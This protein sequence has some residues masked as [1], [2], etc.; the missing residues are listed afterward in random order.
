MAEPNK[1]FSETLEAIELLHPSPSRHSPEHSPPPTPP[2]SFTYI[3]EEITT[4]LNIIPE[5]P[6]DPFSYSPPKSFTISAPVK[7]ENFTELFTPRINTKQSISNEVRKSTRLSEKRVSYVNLD[8]DSKDCIQNQK[9]FKPSSSTFVPYD[10]KEAKKEKMLDEIIAKPVN[11]ATITSPYQT[12]FVPV[13]SSNRPLSESKTFDFVDMKKRHVHLDDVLQII[14]WKAFCEIDEFIYSG[15]VQKFYHSATILEGHDLISA[16]VNNS[17]ILITTDILAKVFKIPNSGVQLFGRKWYDIAGVD[18]NTVIREMFEN[19]Q[20]GKDFPVTAL[21]NEYKILHNLC[22][23][24]LMP[25]SSAKYRVNDTD[26]MVLYHLTN[27]KR[28]NLPYLIIQ[29][30]I[31]AIRDTN[32]K[33]G[34][35]YAMGLTKIFKE[36]KISFIGEDVKR[37]WKPFTAKNISHIKVND[38]PKALR[39][40]QIPLQ[41]EPFLRKEAEESPLLKLVNAMVVLGHQISPSS[42]SIHS[43]ESPKILDSPPPLDQNVSTELRLST[44]LGNSPFQIS[45]IPLPSV[46]SSALFGSDFLNKFLNDSPLNEIPPGPSHFSSF[47]SYKSTGTSPRNEPPVETKKPVITNEIILTELTSVHAS[48]NHLLECFESF[49]YSCY[50]ITPPVPGFYASSSNPPGNNQ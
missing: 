47:G 10:R 46:N 44:G 32:G 45:P 31:S 49:I 30:M 26:L 33:G 19:V 25:R 11:T 4:P 5:D 1:P 38:G 9:R 17:N 6:I 20:P 29:H 37:N 28:V 48:V 2:A 16:D 22:T 34:L 12:S 23:Y 14:G 36:Y 18:R 15:L 35:P 39:I 27:G 13:G 21:K 50:D 40:H 42:T 7:A 43:H 3:S 41:R 8:D 24:S